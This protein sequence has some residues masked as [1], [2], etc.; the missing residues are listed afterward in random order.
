MTEGNKNIHLEKDRDIENIMGSLLRTGVAAAA[1]IVAF[2][3]FLYLIKYGFT[4]PQY[5]AFKGEPEGLKSIGG[6][7]KEVLYFNSRGIMQLGLLVLIAT[8]VARVIFAI[9]GFA[10]EK[11]YTYTVISAIVLGILLF[12]LFT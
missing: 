8:P 6:I 2:G 7:L 4:I 10:L 5:S 3:A 9:I 1:A 11:D 12:S